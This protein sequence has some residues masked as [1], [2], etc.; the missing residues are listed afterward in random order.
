MPT[1]VPEGWDY[2]DIL[3]R[4]I[5]RSKSWANTLKPVDLTSGSS[6]ERQLG[7]IGG[8]DLEIINF[9]QTDKHDGSRGVQFSVETEAPEI[10]IQ[11]D[12]L[13]PG[14]TA[15][16]RISAES[17]ESDDDTNILQLHPLQ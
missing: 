10:T 2:P 3:P 11:V 5:P 7:R 16:F 14:N 1:A 13:I 15:T 17:V 6:K 8:A 4:H 9:A 12:R